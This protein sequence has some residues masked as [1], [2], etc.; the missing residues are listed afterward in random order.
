[1]SIAKLDF[2]WI[3]IHVRHL[4]CGCMHNLHGAMDGTISSII[5]SAKPLKVKRNSFIFLR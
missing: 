2:S 4:L 1:M 3:F 5:N